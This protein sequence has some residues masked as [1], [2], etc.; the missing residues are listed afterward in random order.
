MIHIV[1]SYGLEGSLVVPNA[2]FS[3]ETH[4]EN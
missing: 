1:R 4:Y 2:Y 3:T